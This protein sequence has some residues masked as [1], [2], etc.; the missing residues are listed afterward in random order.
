[1]LERS[2]LRYTPG[3]IP[4]LEFLVGH[5]SQQIE[6]GKPRMVELELPCIAVETVALL[7]SGTERTEGVTPEV[8][9]SGF[10][11]ARSL[12][13]PTP[14]LHVTHLEFVEGNQNGI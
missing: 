14:V 11:A 4:V 5:A 2:A 7:L 3:G 8:S 13:R 12:K 9:I 6:A 1:L 10:L